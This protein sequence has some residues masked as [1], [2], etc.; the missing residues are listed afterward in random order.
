MQ[1]PLEKAP[2]AKAKGAFLYVSFVRNSLGLM[3]V[4][5]EKKWLKAYV[6]QKPEMAAISVMQLV[7]PKFR[8]TQ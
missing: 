6:S 1:K 2:F 7:K 5:F 4:S 8:G 3:P